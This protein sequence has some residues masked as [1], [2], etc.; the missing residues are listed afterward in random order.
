MT[1]TTPTTRMRRESVLE[2]TMRRESTMR[3]ASLLETTI[4]RESM[5]R[6][7]QTTTGGNV[8]S[9]SAAAADGGT[10][11]TTNT[12]TTTVELVTEEDYHSYFS[13]IH[14]PTE[15]PRVPD[16]PHICDANTAKVIWRDV[17]FLILGSIAM[18]I[19]GYVET[20]AMY[21]EK[22]HATSY[23]HNTEFVN[24]T[25]PL[26]IVDTGY[27]VT[28]PLYEYLKENRTMNDWFA[29]MNSVV[30]IFPS[31]YIAYVT[32]WSGDYS[33]VFR[34][35]GVQLL[36]S[37]CGWFTYLP[38]DP[39]YLNSYYDFPD[40]VQCLFKDCHAEGENA[41][42]ELLPFVSFFSGH[43]ATMV[44]VGNHMA[45]STNPRTKMWAVIMH[46][47]NAL[48]IVR[49][50]A[51]RGHFSIDIII[52]WAVAV[53]VSNPAERL[54]RYYSR[55]SVVR[56]FMPKSAMEAFEYAT[57]V[58]ETRKE[59]RMSALMGRPE[60]REA[61]YQMEL[62][63]KEARVSGQK[64]ISDSEI[65][66]SETTANILQEAASKIMQEHAQ[67]LQNDLLYLQQRATETLVAL[68]EQSRT[69][70]TTSRTSSLS[71][72]NSGDENDDDDNK[73]EN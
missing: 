3:R 61:L 18:S 44:A 13:N 5:F 31:I 6:L 29:F 19:I 17:F 12:T 28:Y 21:I 14:L 35:L 30:L 42:P 36:R 60:V 9:S 38:P 69:S 73:K 11:A 23:I 4:R 39:S 47:L 68:R 26:G 64:R 25:N 22:R 15:L 1:T 66:E 57:G 20:N 27:I 58:A 63:A 7:Q 59:R 71:R 49:L 10:G 16:L 34:V 2:A 41:T 67:H 55:G 32:V 8:V 70:T 43:V 48:Q 40:F 65:V 45:L 50:L 33:C 72:D 56:E 37:F 52:G 62:E 51:T 24:N 54:G 46:I 53:Y